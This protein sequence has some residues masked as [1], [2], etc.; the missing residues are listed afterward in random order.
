M[1]KTVMIALAAGATGYFVGAMVGGR[2]GAPPP[3][4]SDVVPIARMARDMRLMCR[5]LTPLLQTLEQAYADQRLSA[6]EL[7]NVAHQ[8]QRLI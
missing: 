8:A 5:D 4:E 1:F 7:Y 3:E 2:R 6:G